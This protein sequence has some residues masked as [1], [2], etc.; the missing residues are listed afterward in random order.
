LFHIVQPFL[1]LPLY[2]STFSGLVGIVL[3]LTI[4]N[5]WNFICSNGQ[6]VKESVHLSMQFFGEL[7]TMCRL[8][9]RSIIFVIFIIQCVIG[10]WFTSHLPMLK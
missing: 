2:H 3:F 8:Y 5:F 4:P 6:K 10:R 7:E 1:S 9:L